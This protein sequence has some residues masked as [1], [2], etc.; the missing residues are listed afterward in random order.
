MESASIVLQ[1]ER[2]DLV[3]KPRLVMAQLQQGKHLVD[4][5]LSWTRT[6]SGR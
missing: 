1:R 2:V 5:T 6:S 4:F 3:E